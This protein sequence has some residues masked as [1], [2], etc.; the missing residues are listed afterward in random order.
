MGGSPGP[1]CLPTSQADAAAAPIPESLLSRFPEGLEDGGPPSDLQ[2]VIPTMLAGPCGQSQ[3][4]SVSSRSGTDLLG[5]GSPAG[6][7]PSEHL[8]DRRVHKTTEN[9]GATR[10]PHRQ[11]SCE[12]EQPWLPLPAL[13]SLLGAG[14]PAAA[15]QGPRPPTLPQ[16]LAKQSHSGQTPGLLV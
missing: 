8:Q 3:G 11:R 14:A 13:D 10:E 4:G 16:S 12:L 1:G 15:G 2:A 7:A 6:V 5:L 9:L